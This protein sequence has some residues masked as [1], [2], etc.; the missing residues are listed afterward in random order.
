MM[1]PKALETILPIGFKGM[2]TAVL[3]F[4]MLSTDT[5]YIHSRGAIFV[6]DVVMPIYGKK[7]SPKVHL[8]MLRCSL[9]G[10]AIFAFLFSV[11]YQ[12]SEYIH[13]LHKSLHQAIHY[14]TFPSRIG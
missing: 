3:F 6:Q 9:A 12:Q 1:L 7:L 2:V 10:V 5:T 11:F 14:H 13:F 4:Y 8:L